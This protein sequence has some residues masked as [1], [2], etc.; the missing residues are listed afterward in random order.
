MVVCVFVL[1]WFPL[2]YEFTYPNFLG[3]RYV[4]VMIGMRDCR[5]TLG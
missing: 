5:D 2:V 3:P 4:V 1:A